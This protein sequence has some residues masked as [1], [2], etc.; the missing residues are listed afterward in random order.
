MLGDAFGAA[1]IRMPGDI[2]TAF[3]R[4]KNGVTGRHGAIRNE[5][6]CAWLKARLRLRRGQASD[7]IRFVMLQLPKFVGT[8]I[9]A[10]RSGICAADELQRPILNKQ[11]SEPCSETNACTG[12]HQA[13]SLA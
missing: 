6:F 11:R 1:R 12:K 7:H 13:S 3:L 10:L 4:I 9:F 2:E 5:Y 8:A